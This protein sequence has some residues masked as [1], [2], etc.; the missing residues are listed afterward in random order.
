MAQVRWIAGDSRPPETPGFHLP[1]HLSLICFG[2]R[3]RGNSL[4]IRVSSRTRLIIACAG[5][6]GPGLRVPR[7]R[8]PIPW[9][10]TRGDLLL[11]PPVGHVLVLSKANSDAKEYVGI[12]Y[13]DQDG[14]AA[15]TRRG[16]GGAKR[17]CAAQT[18]GIFQTPL[19]ASSQRD[20][21]ASTLSIPPF[22]GRT[23]IRWRHNRRHTSLSRTAW[24]PDLAVLLGQTTFTFTNT[25]AVAFHVAAL[26]TPFL[27]CSRNCPPLPSV[28]PFLKSAD[29]PAWGAFS[30]TTWSHSGVVQSAVSLVCCPSSLQPLGYSLGPI[31]LGTKSGCDSQDKL[32]PV[33]GFSGKG[34]GKNN[35]SLRGYLFTFLIAVGFTLIDVNWAPQSIWTPHKAPT[36]GTVP[37]SEPDHCAEPRQ[38]L[39]HS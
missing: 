4:G 11:L 32:H 28:H 23:A 35:E 34:Y 7:L 25:V 38:E 1:S 30:W 9:A 26:S 17:V 24:A 33:I 8:H 19:K 16:S 29:H 20:N 15:L 37:R 12:G 36:T 3:G 39:L 6:L 2:Q 10:P 22:R 18:R 31:S 5:G 14:K 27:T 21:T 13:S